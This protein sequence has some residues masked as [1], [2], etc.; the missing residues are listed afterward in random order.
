MLSQEE[1]DW[2]K[3]MSQVRIQVEWMFGG[4]TN[5][6]KFL[7]FKKN[8]KVQLSAVGKIYIVCNLLQ[9]QG[10]V[11]MGLCWQITLENYLRLWESTFSRLTLSH[12]ELF[13]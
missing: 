6:F 12:L 7:D 11:F 10:H 1:I 13:G 8:M 5:Y 9:K 2:N 3:A 4:I